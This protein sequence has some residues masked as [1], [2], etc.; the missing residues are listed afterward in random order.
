MSKAVTFF[1]SLSDPT[2]LSCLLLLSAE[3]ELCVCELVEALDAPQSLVSRHLAQLR[4]AGLVED[5]RV[6]PGFEN[7]VSGP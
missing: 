1:K 4:A 2:R 6:T 3:Q 5:E 7:S